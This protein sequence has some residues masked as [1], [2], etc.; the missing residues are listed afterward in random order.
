MQVFCVASFVLLLLSRRVFAQLLVSLALHFR[1]L[2]S[3]LL[4]CLPC[5]LPSSPQANDL[6]VLASHDRARQRANLLG[7]GHCLCVLCRF[8]YQ[9]YQM[10]DS[11]SILY[12]AYAPSLRQQH[13]CVHYLS[14]VIRYPLT[15]YLRP[16]TREGIR[17]GATIGW[18]APRDCATLDTGGDVRELR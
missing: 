14:S 17:G 16:T 10:S 13:S 6:E 18:S 1:G 2:F 4:R 8:L 15:A 9:K 5:L 7:R 11:R 3:I 12:S